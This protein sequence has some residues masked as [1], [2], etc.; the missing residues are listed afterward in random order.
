MDRLLRLNVSE[1][2]LLALD[3]KP[4]IWRPN[5]V[6]LTLAAFMELVGL[7]MCVLCDRIEFRTFGLYIWAD[8]L[9][10]IHLR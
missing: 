8:D 3:V 7:M 10:Y 4:Q 1:Q 5:D 9:T 2:L 6:H